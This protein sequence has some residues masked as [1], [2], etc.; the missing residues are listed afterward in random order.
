MLA[1]VYSTQLESQADQLL[2]LCDLMCG[3]LCSTT[4]S[5]WRAA[6]AGA[7]CAATGAHTCTTKSAWNPRLGANCRTNGSASSAPTNRCPV[8][9]HAIPPC[10]LSVTSA[11]NLAAAGHLQRFTRDPSAGEPLPC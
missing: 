11:S 10:D 8:Q 6:K 5:A 7:L 4:T 3:M 2:S 1:A 9:T